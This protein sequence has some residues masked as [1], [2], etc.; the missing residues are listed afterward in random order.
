[1]FDIK[2]LTEKLE[3]FDPTQATENLVE[4]QVILERMEQRL[5]VERAKKWIIEKNAEGKPT[6]K[7]VEAKIDDDKTIQGLE[8]NIII[9]Q[10]DYLS[11]KLKREDLYEKHN[12]NK[13]I[14]DLNKVS[15]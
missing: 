14:A 4:A 2:D 10:G 3:S 15:Y 7:L 8:D 9:A 13:K 12:S 11:A 6:D 5:K 1:M